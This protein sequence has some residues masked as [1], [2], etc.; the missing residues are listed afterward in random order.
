MLNDRVREYLAERDLRAVSQEK[1]LQ[2]FQTELRANHNQAKHVMVDLAWHHQKGKWGG[3]DYART[4]WGAPEHWVSQGKVCGPP[5]YRN[6]IARELD[7]IDDV[8]SVRIECAP[9]PYVGRRTP[10]AGRAASPFRG[11]R[12]RRHLRVGE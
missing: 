2:I 7:K 6:P 1:L 5:G 11:R 10:G 12:P 9:T 4:I 3:V 8:Q